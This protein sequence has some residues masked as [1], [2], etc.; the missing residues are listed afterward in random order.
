[1]LGDPIPDE[2]NSLARFL[3]VIGNPV[4]LEI[5]FCLLDQPY[6]VCELSTRLNKRQPCISQH[7]MV[8][9]REELVQSQHEGW[10]RYYFIPSEWIK[11]CLGYMRAHWP[12]TG[13]SLKS[14]EVLEV[15]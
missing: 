10:K 6:C 4:R 1:M 7:L 13:A 3:H 12:G 9:R 11:D 2:V 8:L 14:S 15:D 5:L